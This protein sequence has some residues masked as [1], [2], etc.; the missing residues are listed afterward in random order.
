MIQHMKRSVTVACCHA[1]GDPREVVKVETRELDD[2]QLGPDEVLVEMLVAPINP[3]DINLIQ[4]RYGKTM[5]LPALLGNE[6]AGRV[7][8]VGTAVRGLRLGQLV[9][10][11]PG[12]GA[13]REALITNADRLMSL[14]DG[15]EPEQAATLCINAATAWRMLHDYVCL[16]PGDWVIQNASNS[17]V[18]RFVIQLSRYL[19][20]RTVNVVR[21]A[22]LEAELKPLGADHVVTEAIDLPARIRAM[23]GGSRPALGFNAVGGDSA[24]NLAKALD[25]R[26]TLVT[27][28]AMGK[29]PLT[30]PNALVIF[31]EITFRG[32]W[33]S[34]WYERATVDARNTMFDALAV[35]LKDGELVSEVEQRYPLSQ[36]PEAVAHAMRPQ[37]SGKILLSINVP[38]KA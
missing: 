31:N 2:E 24:L 38:M 33:V 20:F 35:L 22:E 25:K 28:G 23:T 26:G 21:R 19:G 37:R 8:A 3:A 9:R 4:G 7:V 1:F 6:G 18:G 12:V 11:V 27:Y 30:I 10:P 34:A 36:A 15:L 5:P 17:A 13:W 32:F 16:Q 29:Q 14:P